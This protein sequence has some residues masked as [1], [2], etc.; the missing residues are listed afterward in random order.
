MGGVW[1]FIG[2]NLLFLHIGDSVAFVALS[3]RTMNGPDVK[4][5]S[6]S[7]FILVVSAMS[8]CYAKIKNNINDK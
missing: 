7:L 5:Q 3:R 1:R 6:S 4:T 8:V 2:L